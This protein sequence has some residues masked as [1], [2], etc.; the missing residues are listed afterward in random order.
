[1]EYSVDPED[2]ELQTLRKLA[3]K[4]STEYPYDIDPLV[5]AAQLGT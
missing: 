4:R 2:Q 1:M 5:P 3:S